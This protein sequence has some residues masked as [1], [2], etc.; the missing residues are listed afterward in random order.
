MLKFYWKMQ[1]TKSVN[2]TVCV[3]DL[4]IIKYFRNNTI[5]VKRIVFTHLDLLPY[6]LMNINSLQLDYY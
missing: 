1:Q 3:P 2:T 6:A 5:E 4:V